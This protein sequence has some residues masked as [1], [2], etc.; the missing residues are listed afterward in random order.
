MHNSFGRL[1]QRVCT[2]RA[3]YTTI[4]VTPK[5]NRGRLQRVAVKSVVLVGLAVIGFCAC[6]GEGHYCTLI[7]CQDQLSF[8]L[9]PSQ[10]VW[11]DG[12]Y[13]LTFSVDDVSHVCSF[14]L[15]AD[16]PDEGSGYGSIS[17]DGG[18]S[19]I[20]VIQ[21]SDCVE[22]HSGG[23]VGQSCTP[24]P[25]HYKVAASFAGTPTNLKLNLSRDGTVLL[26]GESTPTYVARSPNGEGCGPVCRQATVPLQFD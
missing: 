2:T 21:D 1:V 17:C 23:A 3:V 25:G 12:M 15:P 14:Q 16:L 24:I 18:E 4:C 10:G 9:R 26:H 22:V 20:D 5:R 11:A 8:E 19:S 13:E 7:G 6:V